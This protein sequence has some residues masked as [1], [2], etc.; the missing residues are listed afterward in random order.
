MSRAA[1]RTRGPLGR[2]EYASGLRVI[3]EEMPGVRSVT[4]GIW[5]DVGSRDERPTIAGSSH[6]LEHLLFKGTKRRTAR[7]IAEAFDAVGGD[8]NA[9]SAKESTTYHSRVLDRD[10]PMAVEYLC[11]MV[12]NS[13]ISR[14][15]V[16]AERT[17]IL[18]E[19]V[20]RDDAPDD[21]IPDLFAETLW[22]SNPLGRP[23]LGTR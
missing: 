18:E 15:D 14:S 8:L 2:T 1:V 5:V 19:I 13:L 3:T 9:Y 10:L 23:V 16:E 6:F 11:D 20:V 21:L 7:D 22:Q 12:Q 4:F 17:V